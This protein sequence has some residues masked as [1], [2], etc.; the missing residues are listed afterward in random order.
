M[1]RA[2]HFAYLVVALVALSAA[3]TSP[4]WVPEAYQRLSEWYAEHR[5]ERLFDQAHSYRQSRRFDLAAACYSRIIELQPD[6][7]VC[8]ALRR[9]IYVAL[10]KFQLALAD[11]DHLV[12]IGFSPDSFVER[13]KILLRL[14]AHERALEDCESA[15]TSAAGE[16]PELRFK[17]VDQALKLRAEICESMGD[18]QAALQTIDER[19]RLSL[20]LDESSFVQRA[21]FYHRLGDFENA[22]RDFERALFLEDNDNSFIYDPAVIARPPYA[23]FLATCASSEYRDGKRALSMAL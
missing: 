7:L 15:I 5:I 10:G 4:A 12:E 19:L 14:Q 21:T 23:F 16:S 22:R 3:L 6:M 20:E 13:G 17:T 2:R 9:D 11:A 18:Q 1:R 8:Y